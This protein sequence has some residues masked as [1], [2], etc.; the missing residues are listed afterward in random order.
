[1]KK[2]VVLGMAILASGW[3]VSCEEDEVDDFIYQDYLAG[4]WVTTEMGTPR[5]WN[6]GDEI[7]TVI[8]YVPVVNDDTCGED[9]L[10]IKA[11][12]TYE[13]NDFEVVGGNC[14]DLGVSGTY[15][16]TGNNI[17][18]NYDDAGTPR[19]INANINV[20]TYTELIV[21]YR[22]PGTSSLRFFKFEKQQAQ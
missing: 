13:L 6:N 7:V 1:M 10:I 12:G 3:M 11:D 15:T 2:F 19:V 18:L 8:D 17:A 21:S 22:V 4:T 14:T 5:Q 9:G 16:R 20:L